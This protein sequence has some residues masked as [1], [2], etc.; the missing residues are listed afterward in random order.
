MITP[1][2]ARS[3]GRDGPRTRAGVGRHVAFFGIAAA[4]VA[5]DQLTKALVRA[6]LDRGESWPDGWTVQFTHVTNTGAAFGMF[7]GATFFLAAT[8]VFGVGAILLYYFSPPSEHR[9]AGPALGLVLGGA[10][11][12]FIDRVRLGHV[13][14]FIDFP[15][16]AKF[17]V[18][19]SAITVGVIALFAL[20]LLTPP[21]RP[22]GEP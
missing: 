13:T 22:R 17:N 9:L 2:S 12:N 19:D 15:H 11:G 16:Y 8:T 5:L 6:N 20:M 10:I 18:A 7:E 21:A 14:D 4:I 1:S 3:E